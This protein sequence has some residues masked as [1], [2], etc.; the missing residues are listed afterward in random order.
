MKFIKTEFGNLINANY[1][2]CIFPDYDC[3]PVE[4]KAELDNGDHYVI[5]QFDTD[6]RKFMEKY[7]DVLYELLN[8]ED[9]Q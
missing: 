2:R 9:Y 3:R 4:V 6:C 8:E 7:I 1:I 5:A